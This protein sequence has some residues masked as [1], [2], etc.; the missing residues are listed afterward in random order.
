[1]AR[2]SIRPTDDNDNWLVFPNPAVGQIYVL[3]RHQPGR[4]IRYQLFSS[5]GRLVFEEEWVQGKGIDLSKLSS[6][7]Y[8][9][10]IRD[11]NRVGQFRVV[12]R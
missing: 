1:M 9:L 5:L 2:T 10:M 7:I 3:P 12:R 8:M 11:G 6:G 4:N